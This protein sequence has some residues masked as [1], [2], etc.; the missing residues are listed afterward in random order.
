MALLPLGWLKEGQIPSS[1]NLEIVRPLIIIKKIYID[2][3][4]F[5]GRNTAGGGASVAKKVH[6]P[7]ERN[8]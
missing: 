3:P 1:E 8:Y 7:N 2:L 5:Y 6:N 4:S